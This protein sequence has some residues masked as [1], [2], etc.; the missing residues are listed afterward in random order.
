MGGCEGGSGWVTDGGCC[1][2][3]RGAMREI[4]GGDGGT[5]ARHTRR[6]K[7]EATA[8]KEK[9]ELMGCLAGAEGGDVVAIPKTSPTA[10]GLS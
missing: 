4:G 8:S 6:A 9:R 3:V 7:Q 1:W 10:S 5:W 2:L